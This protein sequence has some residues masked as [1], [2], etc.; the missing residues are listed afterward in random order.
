M[1]NIVE[2]ENWSKT[3]RKQKLQPTSALSPSARTS[4]DAN[5]AGGSTVNARKQHKQEITAF[6][7]DP[8]AGV[9]DPMDLLEKL[10]KRMND[11][12]YTNNSHTRSQNKLKG[13]S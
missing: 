2:D 4:P 9:A 12:L 3:S 11:K 6:I 8:L 13:K 1:L 10:D 5:I 7:D